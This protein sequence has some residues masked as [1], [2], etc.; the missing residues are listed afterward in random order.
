MIELGTIA[1]VCLCVIGGLILFNRGLDARTWPAVSL[2][3]GQ[4]FLLWAVAIT[5]VGNFSIFELLW[6]G[7]LT[8]C[9]RGVS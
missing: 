6:E 3:L 2:R 5:V 7:L 9:Q 4:A 8:F 1:L